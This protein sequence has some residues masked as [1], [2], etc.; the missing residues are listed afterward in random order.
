MIDWSFSVIITLMLIALYLY[1]RFSSRKRAALQQE[2]K[3]S[4]LKF[5]HHNWK[6]I[7]IYTKNCQVINY[8]TQVNKNSPRYQPHKDEESFYEFLNKDSSSVEFVDVIRS[9]IICDF[10][11]NNE[12]KQRFST[13]VDYDNT[14][15]SFKLNMQ[16]YISV[17][18]DEQSSLDNYF[19]DV[20]FLEKEIN[21]TSTT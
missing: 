10:I 6:E 5:V 19:V 20:S 11:E 9:K 16:D 8:N 4:F 2:S 1:G 13:I 17:Y 7:K 12:V 15:V 21:F 3:D 14:V 18:I